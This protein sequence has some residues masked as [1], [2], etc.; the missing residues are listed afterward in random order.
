MPSITPFPTIVPSLSLHHTHTRFSFVCLHG[1]RQAG[2]QLNAI[3]SSAR[4]SCSPSEPTALNSINHSYYSSTHIPYSQPA[5]S[6][7]SSAA[8]LIL[9]PLILSSSPFW[10]RMNS[11][12]YP[13]LF[14]EN[15]ECVCVCFG[16]VMVDNSDFTPSQV[17]C[18]FTFL[19]RQ[20]AKPDNTLFVNRKLFDQVTLFFFFFLTHRSPYIYEGD[21]YNVVTRSRVK[22]TIPH[23]PGLTDRCLWLASVAVIGRGEREG[24]FRPSHPERSRRSAELGF[25]LILNPH[26]THVTHMSSSS[27]EWHHTGINA[28]TTL[29]SN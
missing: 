4:S 10:S 6:P 27:S 11:Y 18:L 13:R 7:L 29:R 24:A 3:T 9:C 19:A 12:F 22:L 15:C 14:D 5:F 25:I 28:V 17:G 1:H 2:N 16:Q 26:C 8:P 20:L 23:S 21:P